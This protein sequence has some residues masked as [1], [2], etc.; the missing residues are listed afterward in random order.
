MPQRLNDAVRELSSLFP[1]ATLRPSAMVTC[2]ITGR[3]PKPPSSQT[4]KNLFSL[5]VSLFLQGGSFPKSPADFLL[6]LA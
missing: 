1:S 5:H 2:R 4:R 3:L 6:H